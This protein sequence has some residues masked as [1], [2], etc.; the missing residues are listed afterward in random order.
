MKPKTINMESKRRRVVMKK[1]Q[2][3]KIYFQ[4]TIDGK[5]QLLFVTEEELRKTIEA[6]KLK[7]DPQQDVA[8]RFILNGQNLE[9][10]LKMA[11]INRLLKQAKLKRT[12]IIPY[13]LN[14]YLEDLTQKLVENPTIPIAK[15]EHEIERIWF[16]LSQKRRNNVF[17]TGEM[18]VGKTAIAHE[19]ARKISINECPKEFYE[20]H[21]VLFRPQVLNKIKSDHAYEKTVKRVMNFLV[22]NRKNIVLYIDNGLYMKTDE[23]LITMLYACIIKYHIPMMATLDYEDYERYF[24]ADTNIAKYLH[25]VYVEEPEIDELKSMLEMHIPRLEKRYRVK[26]TDEA[27]KFGI[28][29][30]CLSE[31]PALEPGNAISILETASREARRK[32][33]KEVDKQCILSC[34]NTSLKDYENMP[35]EERR[36]TAYHETGHYI[37]HIMSKN[38]KDVK[39][40]CVSIL[41]MMWW[42]GVTMS[43]REPKEYAIYSREYFIDQIAI[44]LAG[45]IAEKKVTNAETTGASNDLMRTNSTAKAII[46]RWGF[47]KSRFSQNRSYDYEDYFLM[48]ESKKEL[49]DDEVQDLI[50]EGTQRAQQMIEENEGLLKEI[51]ERL[52]L[53]EILT[54]EELEQICKEYKKKQL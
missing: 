29:T 23:L 21:V 42:A 9:I 10:S 53:D 7:K 34:Y 40:A 44:L 37:A 48:P 49:I 26:I 30:A 2:A 5:P 15:R 4:V 54:G 19:I 1:K 50:N 35:E 32:T 14:G 31:S 52:M 25:E 46:M 47:S 8:L 6:S 27:I 36:A 17:I 28:Y 12:Q 41:P 39:I 51:A 24:L 43:Y 20:R 33:K 22:E 11:E 45:R 3:V 38:Q 16:Y 18:D 13:S